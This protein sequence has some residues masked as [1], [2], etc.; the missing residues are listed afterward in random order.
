M[1]RQSLTALADHYVLGPTKKLPARVAIWVRTV[2]Y[3]P[4]G[5][6]P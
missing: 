6:I 5:I 4:Q 1:I 2:R 3:N